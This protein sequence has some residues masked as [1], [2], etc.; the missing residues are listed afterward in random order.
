NVPARLRL[1]S[2]GPVEETRTGLV[3]ALRFAPA[4]TRRLALVDPGREVTFALLG[5]TGDDPTFDEALALAARRGA[6]FFLH[7]GDLIYED[8]QMPHLSRI[9][10]TAP[11]PIYV[12]RGNHD[13]RNQARIDFMR[14]LGPPYYTFQIGGATFIVLDDAGNYLPTF[15]R[16]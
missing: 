14:A 5:D 12:A 7:V 9:L 2:A 15:W 8:A 11:V 6:D 4:A 10:A 13:Y 16:G 3:R 1:E